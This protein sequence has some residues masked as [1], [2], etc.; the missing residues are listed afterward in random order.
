MEFAVNHAGLLVFD[1]SFMT[2]RRRY[3]AT[4]ESFFLS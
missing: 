1:D 4:A 3:R 2:I